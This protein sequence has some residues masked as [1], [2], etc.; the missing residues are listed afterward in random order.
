MDG[1]PLLAAVL[2]RL[3]GW[4][5]GLGALASGV[6]LLPITWTSWDLKICLETEC[7]WRKLPRPPYLRR[8]C[9]LKRAHQVKYKRAGNLRKC[10]EAA[11][12]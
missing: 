2:Q 8:W 1:A 12:A 5:A 9:D 4:L 10:V 6:R 7:A 11:G 3:E